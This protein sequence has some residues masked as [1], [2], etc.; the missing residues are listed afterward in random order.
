M[1]NQETPKQRIYRVVLKTGDYGDF[2]NDNN[3][4]NYEDRLVSGLY[5]ISTPGGDFIKITPETVARIEIITE[6]SSK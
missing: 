5:S 1:D 3:F 6:A 2:S 4:D